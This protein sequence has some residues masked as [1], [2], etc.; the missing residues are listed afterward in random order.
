MTR[1]FLAIL[2]LLPA[3]LSALAIGVDEVPNVHLSDSTAFVSNPSG[4]LS[5][6]A[7]RTINSRLR[8]LRA[9]TSAE[10]AVVVVDKA[11]TDIDEFA[12]GIFD[13]WGIGKSDNDNGVLVVVSR[14]DREAVIRTGYGME[15]VLPDVVCGRILRNKMFPSFKQGNYDLGVY[16]GVTEIC[17]ILSDPTYAEEIK[18]KQRNDSLAGA[19]DDYGDEMFSL[20]IGLAAAISVGMIVWV[21]VVRVRAR[22]KFGTDEVA[23]WRALR[24][25]NTFFYVMAF[26]T[27]GMAV[28]ALLMLL[29]SERRLRRHKRNCPECGT[30]MKLLDEQTD[31]NYLNAQQDLEEKLNSVDYDV[32]LCPHCNHTDIRPYV[33]PESAYKECPVCHTHAMSLS[34]RQTITPATTHSEGEGEDTWYCRA[35]GHSQKRRFKIAGKP[36]TD[37]LAAAAAAA[38]IASRRSRRMGR[39]FGGGGFGGGFRGGSFGGGRTGGGGARGRW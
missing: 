23:R 32:W 4:V 5:A 39:G 11:D 25:N 9:K 20:Y 15:G 36:D 12:T 33:N 28:P 6:S 13:K 31:N 10:V 22:R 24:S 17:R 21:I 26:I 30:R 19:G 1:K 37:A 16:D 34:D 29:W 8:E 35:C 27:L 14:D 38:T 3:F 18:S 2:F 7:V